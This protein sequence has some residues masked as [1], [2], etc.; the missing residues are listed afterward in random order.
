MV[1][2]EQVVI[3]EGDQVRDL[4]VLVTMADEERGFLAK[5]ITARS[6]HCPIYRFVPIFWREQGLECFRVTYLSTWS[7]SLERER[8]KSNS[9]TGKWPVLHNISC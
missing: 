2:S 3:V 9:N 1:P 7:I 5:E 6:R 8:S 4:I